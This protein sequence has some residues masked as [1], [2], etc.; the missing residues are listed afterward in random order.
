MS[1]ILHN[2]LTTKKTEVEAA[3]LAI[4]LA[5]IRTQA[6]NQAPARNFLDAIHRGHR[7]GQ[8]AIIA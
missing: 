1:D 4:S 7:S 3:K 5:E 2:I 8:A 6:E